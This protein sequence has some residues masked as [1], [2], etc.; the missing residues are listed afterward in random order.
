MA[1]TVNAVYIILYLR[2]EV[3]FAGCGVREIER[4]T[5][6]VIPH[7]DLKQTELP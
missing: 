4:G 3:D 5:A 2:A 6:A 1:D 7:S